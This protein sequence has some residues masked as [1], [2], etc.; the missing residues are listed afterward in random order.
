MGFF[1][2]MTIFYYTHWLDDTKPSKLFSAQLSNRTIA[3]RSDFNTS[4]TEDKTK[5]V[6]QGAGGGHLP[7]LSE[8][9]SPKS[10]HSDVTK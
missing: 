10:K 4:N 6:E 2:G 8:M 7:P 3:I 9:G 1:C 5:A